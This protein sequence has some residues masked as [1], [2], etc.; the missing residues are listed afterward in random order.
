[1]K[2]R[3]CNSTDVKNFEALKEKEYYICTNCKLVFL[4]SASFLTLSEQKE[5]YD[6]HENNSSD[7]GYIKFLNKLIIPLTKTLNTGASGLDF[8]CGPGPTVKEILKKSNIHMENYDPIY[9]PNKDLLSNSYDFITCTEVVEHL[10][11]P[12]EDFL[13]LKRLIKKDNSKIGI[14]TEFYSSEID[15]KTWWYK[16]DETHVNFFQ[17]ETFL[18]LGKWLNMRVDIPQTNIVILSN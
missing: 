15:F 11:T 12:R 17:E 18:W 13:Q 4:S 14:M 6:F 10:H 2:C 3:L 16:N 1:M 7:K 8:G 9:F 5:R